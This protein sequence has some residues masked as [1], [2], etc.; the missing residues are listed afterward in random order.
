M[1]ALLIKK[2]L[3]GAVMAAFMLAAPLL[4]GS[5]SVAAIVVLGSDGSR[6]EYAVS[7]VDR[8]DFSG[9]GVTVLETDGTQSVSMAYGDVDRILVNTQLSGILS[10]MSEGELAVWPTVTSDVVNISGAGAQTDFRVY[11][12]GGALALAGKTVEGQTCVALSSLP[13]GM[14][15]L[16]IGRH[17]VKIIKK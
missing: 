12:A 6:H 16:A 7:D 10:A 3:K 4:S 17:S 2:G 5:E 11:T 8:I 14:Y 13:S 9:G 15:V 1:S